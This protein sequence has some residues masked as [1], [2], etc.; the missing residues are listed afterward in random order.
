MPPGPLEEIQKA[1]SAALTAL[2][3]AWGPAQAM[4]LGTSISVIL[5][6]LAE[7][8][9]ADAFDFAGGFVIRDTLNPFVA[10]MV[11]NPVDDY[12]ENYFRTRELSPFLA[13]RSY[14]EGALTEDE[15][16][17]NLIDTGHSDHE[18]VYGVKAGRIRLY[19]RMRDLLTKEWDRIEE[20]PYPVKHAFLR[21]LDMA[22]ADLEGKLDTTEARLDTAEL[23]EQVTLREEE[24]KTLAAQMKAKV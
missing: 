18:I 22:L 2:G 19:D 23:T 6:A 9:W 21:T 11:Q 7:Q 4:A 16:I 10:R 5:S 24:L 3:K 12:L 14:A 20:I 1:I 17:E 13:I 15:L 8:P